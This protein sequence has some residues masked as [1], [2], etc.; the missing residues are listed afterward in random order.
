MLAQHEDVSA[1]HVVGEVAVVPQRHVAIRGV[2]REQVAPI[3]GL[4]PA[5]GLVHAVEVDARPHHAERVPREVEVGHG[6][7]DE[8]GV[9]LGGVTECRHE[10]GGRPQAGACCRHHAG[11]RNVAAAERQLEL[12]AGDAG[13][14]LEHKL[15]GVTDGVEQLADGSKRHVVVH[16]ALGEVLARELLARARHGLEGLGHE[17]LEVDDVHALAAK[18]RGKAV[19][20][21]L[22]HL[23]EGDVVKQQAPQVC[24]HEVEQLV[25]GPVQA[26]AAQPAYLARD[27]QRA[28]R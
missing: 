20:L 22:R 9:W 4:A 3:D 5:R 12:V 11:A 6:V 16:A 18:Q 17:T 14:G 7:H 27:A 19:V 21:C 10:R 24:R 28:V 13:H 1:L 15:V 23:E 2:A 25:A 8:L 26:H